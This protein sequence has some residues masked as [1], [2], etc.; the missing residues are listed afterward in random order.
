MNRQ[1]DDKLNSYADDKWWKLV[2]THIENLIPGV[3]TLVP[4][5]ALAHERMYHASFQNPLIEVLED[6]AY[7]G[8]LGVLAFLAVAYLLGVL[9]FT[10]GRL[11]MDLLSP[12]IA[13]PPLFMFKGLL[14]PDKKYPW[15]KVTGLCR[16]LIAVNK[17]FGD[18]VAKVLRHGDARAKQEVGKRRQRARLI[19]GALV[20]AALAFC[21]VCPEV[22]TSWSFW[23][24]F[25]AGFLLVFAHGELSIFDEARLRL[26]EGKED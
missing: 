24:M 19:R 17:C 10:L 12:L 14:R 25:S 26:P 13:R 7:V 18:T 16:K 15:K 8:P 1:G 5:L 9:S 3:A 21:V 20:P 2:D 23:L 11:P 6:Y 22:R 4:L